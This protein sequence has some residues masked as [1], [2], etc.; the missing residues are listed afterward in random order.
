M[1][2]SVSTLPAQTSALR[3]TSQSAPASAAVSQQSYP[4]LVSLRVRVDNDLNKAIL[5]V[6]SNDTGE[7]VAQ[8]PSA[9]QIRAFQRAAELQRAEVQQSQDARAIETKQTV[10]TDTSRQE[11]SQQVNKSAGQSTGDFSTGSGRGQTASTITLPTFT[12]QAAYT[13]SGTGTTSRAAA[14]TPAPQLQQ[15]S[16]DSTEA[17]TAS[18]DVQ[19]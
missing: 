8:Y 13:G 17:S 12:S 7:V 16:G 14:S 10:K 9:A 11:A 2:E 1:I 18:V 6:R 3:V 15:S 19:T 5:E 4:S